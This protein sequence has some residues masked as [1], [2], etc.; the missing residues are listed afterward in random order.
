MSKTV[1]ISDDIHILIVKKQIELYE[2]Y[3]VSV[4][5][6]DITEIVL[7]N[8]VKDADVLFGYKKVEEQE[9]V[10]DTEEYVTTLNVE[11]LAIVPKEDVI[12]RNAIHRDNNV[13]IHTMHSNH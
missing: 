6:S 8:C 11:G 3:G 12:S 13:K 4:K 2:K 1:A 5:L 7:K 10:L 9:T